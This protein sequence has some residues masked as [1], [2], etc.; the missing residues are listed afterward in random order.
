MSNAEDRFIIDSMTWS[1]SRLNFSCLSEWHRHYIECEPQEQNF[2][3]E[4]GSLVHEC[5]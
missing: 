4:F 1:F 3:A 2:Y 5:I